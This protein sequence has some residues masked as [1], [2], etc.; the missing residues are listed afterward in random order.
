[1]F[2]NEVKR[3]LKYVLRIA[4]IRLENPRKVEVTLK[5]KSTLLNYN[6][7]KKGRDHLEH[8]YN[9]KPKYKLSKWQDYMNCKIVSQLKSAALGT[10]PWGQQ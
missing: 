5:Q 4:N 8:I 6:W 1:L 9:G 3:E 10:S 2:I 7:A